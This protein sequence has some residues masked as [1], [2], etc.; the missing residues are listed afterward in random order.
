MP[1]RWRRRRILLAVVALYMIYVIARNAPDLVDWR[2]RR[3]GWEFEQPIVPMAHY[4]YDR[5]DDVEPTGAPAGLKAPK[6]G[7]PS[8]HSYAGLI[9]FYRLAASLQGASHTNGYRSENRNV[10]FA[11]SNLQSAAALLPVVC[12]MSRWNRNW[13]HVAFMGRDDIDLAKILEINGI[14]QIKCPAIWHDARP[15]FSEYSADSRAESSVRAALMHI[16]SFL[17]PQAVIIDDALSE[18]DFFVRGVRAKAKVLGMTLIEGP[19]S[20]WD[21]FM[22]VARLDAGSLRHWHQPSIEI[23]IQ[24]PQ[25]SSSVIRLL[26]SIKG[27][28]YSGLKPPHITIDL[29]AEIDKSVENYLKGFKWPPIGDSS[30]ISIRRRIASQRANQEESAIRFLELFYPTNPSNS[31]VL[32]L[33]PQAELSSQYWHYLKYVLLEYKY[34]AFSNVD[35]ADVMG[36]SLDLPSVLLDGKTKLVPPKTP[37]MHTTRYDEL[38]PETKSVPFM[39]QAPNSHATLFFGD[40]WAE[41]HSFLSNR[42]AKHLQAPDATPRHKLV[43]ETLPSWVEYTLEFMRARGYAL[44]YPGASSTESLITIHNEL[45]H[46]PEEFLPPKPVNDGASAPP[47]MPDEAFLRADETASPP[48]LPESRVLPPSIPLHRLL[49]FDGDLPEIPQLPYLLH[50]GKLIPPANVSNIASTYAA[51]YREAIGGCTPIKDKHRVYIPGS[52]RDLFCFGD[53][54]S[55]D[56]ED[57]SPEVYE[58]DYVYHDAMDRRAALHAHA[59][60]K[61]FIA[62]VASAASAATTTTSSLETPTAIESPVS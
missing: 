8:P 58:D 25:D 27:A 19:Q 53:E 46:T 41:L 52:A 57:D 40:K 37:D 51:R 48:K 42:V 22:W 43:S 62:S 23:L 12:E 31:H 29:P 30:Q 47:R 15:D 33:S 9:K 39:W 59:L 35:G 1:L 7:E 16:H 18:D 32:L 11:V 10:L 44:F 28:D 49:P 38:F 55:E 17:H 24:V 61:P 45:Y 54:D 56:W 4:D 2:P 36:I 50:T 20:Q 5:G 26:Q 14:D 3:E 6:A 60:P 34:S 21:N 13:V